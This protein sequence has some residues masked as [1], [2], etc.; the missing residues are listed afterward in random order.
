MKKKFKP[1]HFATALAAVLLMTA[2]PAG[3]ADAESQKDKDVCR[4]NL[5]KLGAAIHEYQMEKRDLPDWLSDLVPRYLSDTN[6]LFC[7]VHKRTGRT[8]DFGLRDPAIP[9]SYLYEFCAHQAPEETGVGYLGG[10]TNMTM[11][12][13]KLKQML[14]YGAVVPVVRCW[15]HDRVINLAFSGEI[16]ESG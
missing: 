14:Q 11:K 5:T 15:L 16:Y 3:A 2:K 4:R 1:R 13:W 7:P 10:S 8:N 9:T 12:E 6:V